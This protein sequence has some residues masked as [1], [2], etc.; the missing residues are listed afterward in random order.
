MGQYWR[1]IQAYEPYVDK[2]IST[3]LYKSIDTNTKYICNYIK[4]IAL[5]IPTKQECVRKY[6][7]EV[8]VCYYKLCW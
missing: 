6:T 7:R 1:K 3:K 2:H 8:G 4:I 5:I